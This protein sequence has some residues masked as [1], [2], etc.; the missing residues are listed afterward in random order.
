[1]RACMRV[2]VCECAHAC[3]RVCEC[4]HACV[5]ACVCVSACVRVSPSDTLLL[6]TCF[7]LNF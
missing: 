6:L 2:R 5:H 4:A 1:M 3:V 7:F